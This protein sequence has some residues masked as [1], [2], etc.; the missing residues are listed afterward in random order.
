M[1]GRTISLYQFCNRLCFLQIFGICDQ[2]CTNLNASY[3]CGCYGGYD[4]EAG[5]SC[6]AINVPADET[7]TLLFANSVNVQVGFASA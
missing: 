5:R 1:T 4:L 2:I 7:A 3:V 6:K